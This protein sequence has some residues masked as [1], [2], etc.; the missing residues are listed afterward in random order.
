MVKRTLN[1]V[2]GP[3][4]LVGHSYSGATITTSGVDDRVVGLVYIGAA[5]PDVGET[6]QNQ[7]DKFPSDIFFR[8]EVDDG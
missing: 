3:V 2:S 4:L 5:V 6:V 7:L 1:R 8:V